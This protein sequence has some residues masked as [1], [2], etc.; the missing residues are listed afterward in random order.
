M[1]HSRPTYIDSYRRALFAISINDGVLQ[2]RRLPKLVSKEKQFSS[3]SVD[4]WM[5]RER[6]I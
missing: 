1:D 6:V 5:G 3:L 4:F 2:V